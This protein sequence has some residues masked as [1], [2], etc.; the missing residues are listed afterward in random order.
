MTVPGQANGGQANGVWGADDTCNINCSVVA[1]ALTRRLD[2]R[3]VLQISF[4]ASTR[5]PFRLLYKHAIKRA[6]R[7]LSQPSQRGRQAK[8]VRTF[9][10]IFF[11]GRRQAKGVRTFFVIFFFGREFR[12][13]EKL[14]KNVLTPG[15]LTPFFGTQ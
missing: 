2:I 3:F 10:V 7:T 8:G 11:F 4:P 6:G 9:F 5:L 1:S 14:T 13:L 12:L 15:K